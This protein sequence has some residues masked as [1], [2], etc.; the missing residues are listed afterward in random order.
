M[1]GRGGAV[2]ARLQTAGGG[3]GGGGKEKEEGLEAVR[4]AERDRDG[5]CSWC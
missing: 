2:T 1:G 5:R 4:E 3:A